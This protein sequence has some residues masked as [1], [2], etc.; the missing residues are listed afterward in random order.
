[1]NAGSII[2]A[3]LREGR[4][5]LLEHEAMRLMELYGIKVADYGFAE[6]G[7]EAREVADKIGYPVVV[8]VVSPDIS[9]KTDVGGVVLGLKSGEEVERACGAITKNVRERQPGARLTGFLVQ[10]MMPPGVEVIIGATR[11]QVFGPVIMFGLGGIFVEVLKDV[12]FRVAPVSYQ[13]AIEML[14]EIKASRILEGYRSQPPVDKEAIAGM[15]VS[16]SRL[17]EDNPYIISVD[18]NPVIAYSRGA[19]VVDARVIVSRASVVNR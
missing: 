17:M 18:L 14:G 7:R 8:K 11:D 12:T 6:S 3:A 9:H 10:K 13:D 1:M 15:I 19:V 2:E 5:K 16:L 4:S